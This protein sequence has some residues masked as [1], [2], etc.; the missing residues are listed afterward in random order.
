MHCVLGVVPLI[1]ALR[2]QRQ[3][4]EFKDSLTYRA[5]SRTARPTQRNLVS[6]NKNKRGSMTFDN[7]IL[8]VG[9]YCFGGG[10][11]FFCVRL[12]NSLELKSQTVVSCHVVAGN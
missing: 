5:S 4:S 7:Y 8:F 11:L 3:I 1:P 10:C 12:P 9:F 6:K 2:K